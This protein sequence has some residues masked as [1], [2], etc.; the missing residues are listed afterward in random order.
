MRVRRGCGNITAMHTL[1]DLALARRHVEGGRRLVAEQ[2]NRIARMTAI[3]L[4]TD[5]AEN[6]LRLLLESLASMEMHWEEIEA[7]IDS[8]GAAE[9]SN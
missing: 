4:P 8:S 7:S 2:C 6:F 9:I 5:Q 1:A 3:G